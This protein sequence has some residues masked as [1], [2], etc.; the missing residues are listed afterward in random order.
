[1]QTALKDGQKVIL[2]I[3]PEAITDPA[4]AD[5]HSKHI[6]IINAHVDVVE[7]AGADTFVVT[8]IAGKE[9]TA[10]LRADIDVTSG[11]AMDFA[12]NMDKAV[13]FDPNSTQLI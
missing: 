5:Q 2:G 9:V 11:A 6:D 7:P 4:S 13:L 12:F 1:M 3:R 8:H 10:R